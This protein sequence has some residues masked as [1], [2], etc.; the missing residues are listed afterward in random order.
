VTGGAGPAPAVPTFVLIHGAAADSWCWHRLTAELRAR[1]YDVVPVD[2]PCDDE[3]AGLSEY[4]DAVLAAV[5]DRT[6]L[7]VVAHSFGGFTAPIV[8]ARRPVELL[9]LLGAQLPTPGETPG[10]WW[11][12][13]GYPAARRKRDVQDGRAE[14][15]LA[16]LFVNDLPPDLAAEALRRSRPQAGTPFDEPWPLAAWP[17]VPTRVLLHRDDRFLPAEFVRRLSR[18]RLGIEP[19]EM[20]GDHLGMLGHPTELADRLEQYWRELPGLPPTTQVRR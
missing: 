6:G 20:A 10:D 9:V 2:L 3:S 12:R 7:V 5:G 1:G 16:G 8:C 11:S 18:E 14:D 19:D 17:A 13:T 15:D 4:A